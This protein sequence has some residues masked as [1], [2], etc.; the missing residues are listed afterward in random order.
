MAE[1]YR[2]GRGPRMRLEVD[3]V[4]FIGGMARF[5]PV[6]F[7]REKTEIIGEQCSTIFLPTCAVEPALILTWQRLPTGVLIPA[8]GRIMKNAMALH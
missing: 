6:V 3:E 1:Q 2:F 7:H 5:V 8:L 4:E